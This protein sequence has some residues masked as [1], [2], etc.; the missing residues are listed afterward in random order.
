VGRDE[1]RVKGTRLPWHARCRIFV[2]NEET[3]RS[4][5]RFI[6]LFLGTGTEMHPQHCHV[7][8]LRSFFH[9]LFHYL[10]KSSRYTSSKFCIRINYFYPHITISFV[11]TYHCLFGFIVYLYIYIYI[12]IYTKV[13]G[14][15]SSDL[16]SE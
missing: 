8:T 12:Y 7:S 3:L 5:L 1:Y 2:E 16:D 6:L 10:Y 4:F 13:S 15:H 14:V 9:C 11:S